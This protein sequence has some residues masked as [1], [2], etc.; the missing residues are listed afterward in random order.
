MLPD[1]VAGSFIRKKRE[2]LVEF[3]HELGEIVIAVLFGKVVSLYGWILNEGHLVLV[4]FIGVC[5]C[6]VRHYLHDAV[7]D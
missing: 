6:K 4:E 1:A 7:L 5:N 2:M 3:V